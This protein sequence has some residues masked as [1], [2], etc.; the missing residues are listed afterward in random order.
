MASDIMDT[1]MRSRTGA[2]MSKEEESFYGRL[3]P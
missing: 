2:A 3:T 1:L